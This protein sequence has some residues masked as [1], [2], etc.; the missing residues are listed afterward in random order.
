MLFNCLQRATCYCNA[1]SS[2]LTPLSAPVRG[3]CSS[4]PRPYG[5][6]TKKKFKVYKSGDLVGQSCDPLL[7]SSDM[8]TV[9]ATIRARTFRNPWR[10]SKWDIL[11]AD[12]WAVTL[13]YGEKILA[14]VWIEMV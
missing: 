6:Q 4:I 9:D 10:Q 12:V 14:G 8:A 2:D 11:C 5:G 1:V 7:L 13:S 3:S